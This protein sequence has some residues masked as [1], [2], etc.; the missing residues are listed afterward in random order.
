MRGG[1]APPCSG[2]SS[3]T[4]SSKVA[5]ARFFSTP[6]A[7]RPP[8]RTPTRC[9]ASMSSTP[10]RRTS[11]RVPRRRV[12]RRHPRPCR[13][14]RNKSSRRP[15]VER[16]AGPARLDDGERGARQPEPTATNGEPRHAHL[17]VQP[18]RSLAAGHDG[19]LRR[20]HHR[21][22]RC[23]TFRG[24]IYGDTDINAAFAALRKQ[25]CPQTG[26]TATW[27]RS[28]CRPRRRS[29]R[30]TSPTCCRRE[31]CSIRTRSSSMAG[32]RTRW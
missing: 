30:P 15:D 31:G 26:G 13:A 10:S 32:R 1:W 11:R 18:A 20:A 28:T 9:A 3:T 29:T 23:T 21:Q 24:R 2:S 6:E 8:A 25:T 19:A 22:A 16:A 12:V 4:A 14:R 5:T 17:P 27:R 7:R